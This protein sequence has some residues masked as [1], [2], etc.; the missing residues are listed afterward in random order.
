MIHIYVYICN[1]QIS[2]S[3]T[4]V[5]ATSMFTSFRIGVRYPL[6]LTHCKCKRKYILNFQVFLQKRHKTQDNPIKSSPKKPCNSS[7][8]ENR[9]LDLYRLQKTNIFPQGFT[10][11]Q[12][13]QRNGLKVFEDTKDPRPDKFTNSGPSPLKMGQTSKG[14]GWELPT[15][16]FSGA[17]C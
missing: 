5:T 1:K 17:S 6:L 9:P 12:Q 16:H 4:L 7:H 2:N 15:I 3:Q 8:Q 11:L 14:K 10:H 13:V